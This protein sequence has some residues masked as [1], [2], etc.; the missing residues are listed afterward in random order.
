MGNTQLSQL[1]LLKLKGLRG[2]DPAQ[3]RGHHLSRFSRFRDLIVTV[4]QP[5]P[6]M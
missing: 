6:G 1:L 4:S 3:G 2:R 5:Y